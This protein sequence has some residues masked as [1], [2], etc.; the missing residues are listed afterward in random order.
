MSFSARYDSKCSACGD[1]IYEGDTVAWLDGLVVHA[2][3][4]N[5]ALALGSSVARASDKDHPGNPALTFL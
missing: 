4:Y 2:E 5:A 3:C 1:L